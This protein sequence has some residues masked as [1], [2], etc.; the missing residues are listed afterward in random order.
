MRQ[1][2]PLVLA[3]VTDGPG[4]QGD[5][6][7]NPY[8]AAAVGTAGCLKNKGGVG[9]KSSFVQDTEKEP[10]PLERAELSLR[11][12]THVHFLI[13]TCLANCIIKQKLAFEKVGIWGGGG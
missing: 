13:R 10:L 1:S 7:S 6:N 3:Q 4:K 11:F 9:G 2:Q 8:S 5:S 12:K